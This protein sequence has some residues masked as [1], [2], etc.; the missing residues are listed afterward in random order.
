MPAIWRMP[1]SFNPPL[2]GIALAPEHET[3]GMIVK[4]RAFAVN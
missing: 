3:Y 4:A 1:L 2:I